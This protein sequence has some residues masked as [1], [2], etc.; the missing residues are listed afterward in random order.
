M[1]FLVFPV[2]FCFLKDAKRIVTD[3]K[4]IEATVAP[5]LLV[6]NVRECV[7]IMPRHSLRPRQLRW[8]RR[9]P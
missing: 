3:E 5:I 1:F 4:R 7:L 2:F 8:R 9:W 6:F